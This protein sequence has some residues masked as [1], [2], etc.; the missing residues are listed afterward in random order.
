MIN[1]Y[2]KFLPNLS[3]VLAPLHEL[4][5]KETRWHWGKE[6]MQAFQK[7]KDF[8]KSSRLLV[9]YDSQK[10]LTL[11][12]DASQYGLGAVLSHRMDD[13]SEHPIAY[14]SRTLSNAERNYSNLEREALS[15]VFGV[16]KFYQYIY[17]RHFSLVTDHKPLE[18]LFNEKKA[19]P[20]MAAARIQRWALTLAAYNYSIEY[21]PGPEHANADALSRL[22]LPVSPPTTPLPAETVFAMELLNSTP[23]SVNEIRTGTRCDPI[24]SQVIKF[25]QHGWP[26]H[27]S[28]EALKPYFTR[29]DELSV[30]DG[31]L[32]WGNRVVVPPKE[33][34]R[35]VEELHETHWNL[36]YE[37]VGEKLCVVAKNGC[38]LRAEGSAVQSLPGKQEVT[39]RS[40]FTSL[41]MAS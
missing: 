39:A 4:L 1:Y 36:P 23:V 8:L 18:S 6:Q 21:K 37:G 20:P 32:L 38:R 10:K 24:L 11:A 19:T 12:C 5:C 30:Q 3:S 2:Q 9:H 22:P 29:K 26:N 7:S 14:A 16:K 27:N 35:V 33:R 41:G 13:G 17:G 40:P 25:V 28:D 34:A 31:C 15:L